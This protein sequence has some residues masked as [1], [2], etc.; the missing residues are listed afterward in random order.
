[1]IHRNDPGRFI[2]RASGLWTPTAMNFAA[3]PYGICPKACCPNTST[4]SCGDEIAGD[5]A[6]FE[7]DFSETLDGWTASGTW[8]VEDGVVAYSGTETTSGTY[9]RWACK[10]DQ[11]GFAITL[12][13]LVGVPS[14]NSGPNNADVGICFGVNNPAPYMYPGNIAALMKAYGFVDEVWQFFGYIMW[15]NNMSSLV[16]ITDKADATELQISIDSVS[17]GYSLSCYGDENLLTSQSPVQLPFPN[18][19]CFRYGL[20]AVHGSYCEFDNVEFQSSYGS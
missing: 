17:G 11:D 7:D 6:L 9:L 20:T 3:A 10:P 19:Y 5:G 12:S 4:C 14:E 8:T 15:W 16:V 1:M 2:K 18:D 13:A